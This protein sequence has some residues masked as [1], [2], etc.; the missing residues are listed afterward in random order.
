MSTPSSADSATHVRRLNWGGGH[1][2]RP[3]W[4]DFTDV[5]EALPIESGTVDY[6]VSVHALQELAYP[7]LV[8]ALQELLRVLRPAGTLRLV[9]P[10]FDADIRAYTEHDD[11]LLIARDDARSRGGRFIAHLLECGR[12]RTL[13]T[14]D[15]VEEL[16]LDAGFVDV[17]CCRARET[18]SDHQEIVEL[19][20]GAR[21]S[22]FIEATRPPGRRPVL[23]V[24]E[25][26]RVQQDQENLAGWSLDAPQRGL[27]S[28]NGT[29]EIAGWVVGRDSPPV[30]IEILADGKVVG[31]TPV[32][33]ARPDVGRRF[34]L[35]PGS[36]SAGFQIALAAEGEGVSELLL[37]AVLGDGSP[38]PLWTIRIDAS[39][40]PPPERDPS[41]NS[42]P[43]AT[44]GGNA[45][46]GR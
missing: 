24:L 40:V 31:H 19:D 16:L 29:L 8:P 30:G 15:F 26:V 10:D 13:F 21:E 7:E 43:R 23:Q 5:R 42:R 35:S 20:D 37:R 45:P 46:P 34:E 33:L 3:G 17:T 14:A 38:I 36:H 18:A 39:R 1:G 25:T 28:D 41:P 4:I 44:E 22:L 11:D 32:N 12:A 9:L 27:R 2:A 6:A